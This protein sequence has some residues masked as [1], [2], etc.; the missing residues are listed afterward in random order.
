MANRSMSLTTIGADRN[1]KSCLHQD[2]AKTAT[3]IPHLGRTQSHGGYFLACRLEYTR[4]GSGCVVSS[5]VQLV[6]TL[7]PSGPCRPPLAKV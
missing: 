6:D 7:L 5:A 1:N 4:V 2:V 3:V